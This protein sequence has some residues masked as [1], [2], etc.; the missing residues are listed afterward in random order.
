MFEKA[1]VYRAGVKSRFDNGLL[2]E[3]LFFIVIYICC[4][5]VRGSL[6]W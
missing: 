4:S 6:P 3:T 2:A 1:L 5:T